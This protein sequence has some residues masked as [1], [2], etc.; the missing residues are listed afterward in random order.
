MHPISMRTLAAKLK[1]KEMNPEAQEI[2]KERKKECA[3]EEELPY[4]RLTD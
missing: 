1:Q 4:K 3:R 2:Y